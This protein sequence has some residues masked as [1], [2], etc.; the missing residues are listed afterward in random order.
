[1]TNQMQA[2]FFLVIILHL[3]ACKNTG[4]EGGKDV[5]TKSKKKTEQFTKADSLK[6][7]ILQGNTLAYLQ[8]RNDFVENDNAPEFLVWALI[9][10]NKHKY[11]PANYDVFFCLQQIEAYYNKGAGGYTM[12]ILD[13]TTRMLA[14]S[15]LIKAA[16][17][18]DTLAK[19][20]I[21]K[22]YI[23]G[24]YLKTDTTKK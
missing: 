18:D 6:M 22:Y 4:S 1:M 8:L 21:R 2:F 19:S 5:T 20:L 14:I 16:S 15:N 7:K 11:L 9:M 17:K 3:G 10:A 23:K 24:E 13:S 12:D